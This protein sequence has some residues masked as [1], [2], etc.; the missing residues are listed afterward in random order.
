MKKLTIALLLLFP[1]LGVASSRPMETPPK[2]ERFIAKNIGSENFFQGKNSTVSEIEV[3]KNKDFTYYSFDMYKSVS[4]STGV[5]FAPGHLL[6]HLRR[7][8]QTYTL[9]LSFETRVNPVTGL[10]NS[11][12][13]FTFSPVSE[14][15]GK[16]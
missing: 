5:M 15:Y 1:L 14:R 8:E 7:G 12:I 6:H 4:M 9:A 13:V 10:N 2:L 11:I 16:L 3:R